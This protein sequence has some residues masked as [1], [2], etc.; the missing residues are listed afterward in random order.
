MFKHLLILLLFVLS[1]AQ[2]DVIALDPKASTS[3]GENAA[4]FVESNERLPIRSVIELYEQGG[5]LPANQEVLNFG[6][7]V[8]PHW[9][10]VEVSNL[11]S[12]PLQMILTIENSWLDRV[13][14]Y[15]VHH[16]ELHNHYA[17][18]DRY[19][20]HYRPLNERFFAVEES[21]SPGST[22][23]FFR[24]ESPDPL[25]LPM[26]IT[27]AEQHKVYVE[28]D[29]YSYG[30]LYGVMLALLMYNLML[31]LGIRQRQYLYYAIYLGIFVV[32]NLAY[33]GHGFRW[34]WPN[35]TEWQ[36]WAN[37]FLM[38]L[39]SISGLMFAIAFLDLRLSL[40]KLTRAIFTSSILILVAFGCFYWLP[41]GR[42]WSLYLAFGTILI[43]TLMMVVLGVLSLAQGNKA[44]RYFLI[45]SVVAALGG[46]ITALTV[47]GILPYHLLG[48]RAVDIGTVLESTLLALALADQFR[49]T[50]RQRLKAEQMA[51]LDP[52]TGL[53]NRRAFNERAEPYWFNALRYQRNISVVII[54]LDEFKQINDQFGHNIGDKALI[55][56]AKALIKIVR[57]GD[58][59]A[60]WGGEEFV[61]LMPETDL[62]EAIQVAERIRIKIH[63]IRIQENEA[64]IALSASVGVASRQEHMEQLEQLIHKADQALFKA[65]KLGRNRVVVAQN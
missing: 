22:L 43:S 18:G 29:A 53:N 61:L 23:L 56:A 21:F 4:F 15:V 35:A 27:G 52:L 57:A 59:L 17:F 11:K 55:N 36:Q 41:S 20:F 10:A 30:L 13:D 12:E 64:N 1:V 50:Q 6:M 51:R 48:F 31:Y 49:R 38:V 42:E 24:A 3:L 2:A 62:E 28:L 40:P 65:K 9:I 37:P 25:L 5:F 47:L 34:F 44:A 63:Q 19:P 26:F 54:D 8:M 58:V 14:L 33:T 32:M 60:R 45:A 46:A 16:G 7:G 39:Y